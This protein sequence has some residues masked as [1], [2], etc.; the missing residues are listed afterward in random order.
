VKDVGRLGRSI[1]RLA[2][3]K[4]KVHHT[5]GADNVVADSSRMFDGH[6]VTEQG[7]GFLAM[8]QGLPLVY[9]SLEEHQ[10]E[11]PMCK[12][13]LEALK[14]GDPAATKFRLHNSP[15]CYQPKGAKTRQYVVPALL[16]PM[17]LKYF[18]DSPMSGHLGSFKTW[19]KVG[20]QFYCQN[21]GMIFFSLCASV[22]CQWAK[23]A[24]DTKVGLHTATPASY[25]LERVFIDF[26]GPLM[27]TKRGN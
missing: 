9:T 27:R 13:L 12:D 23:P 5:K 22:T 7:E 6:E 18:H 8:I 20:H 16:C 2:P 10:K 21:W 11:D 15:L 19:R 26:M 3:F 25:P 17:L 4:F 14:K 24:Q 1:L